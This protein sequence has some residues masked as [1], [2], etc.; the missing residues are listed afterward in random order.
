MGGFER[1]AAAIAASDVAHD[2]LAV[3]Y[4][5]P[6]LGLVEFGWTDPLR[7]AGQEIPL[8]DYPR[9]DSPYGRCDYGDPRITIHRGDESLLIDLANG[10]DE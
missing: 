3:R 1:F 6:S 2:G 8:R 5:S 10:R 4:R 9:L 7:V